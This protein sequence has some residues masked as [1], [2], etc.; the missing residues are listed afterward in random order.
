MWVTPVYR[1]SADVD[2]RDRA[3]WARMSSWPNS[4]GAP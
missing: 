3:Q 2:E 1:S 4:P